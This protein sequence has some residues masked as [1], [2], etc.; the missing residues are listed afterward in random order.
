MDF[1]LQSLIFLIDPIVGFPLMANLYF[2][3]PGRL[4]IFENSSII[5]KSSLKYTASFEK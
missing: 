1:L 4:E 5:S 3:S 2:F